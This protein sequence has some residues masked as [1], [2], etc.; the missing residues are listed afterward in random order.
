LSWPDPGIAAKQSEATSRKRRRRIGSPGLPREGK[1]V[2][3][4][5]YSSPWV[6]T[7]GQP[8]V[9]VMTTLRDELVILLP[10][11]RRFSLAVT[12]NVQDAEDLLHSALE[13]ALRHEAS[14]Q[15]G[16]RLD[17]WMFRIVRNLWIDERRAKRNQDVS[18]EVAGDAVLEDDRSETAEHLLDLAQ[19]RR[20][21]LSLPEEQ[22]SVLCLVVLEGMTYQEAAATLDVPIG[23]VMSRLSRARA[24]MVSRLSNDPFR[25][26]AIKP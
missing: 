10:R 4:L 22:R 2:L 1:V 7:V 19:A 16:T 14:W 3:A 13:R 24:A 18:L 21:L 9:E 8:T 11:L 17:S 12:G 25:I 20:A 23:T 15:R 26:T 6:V 5:E